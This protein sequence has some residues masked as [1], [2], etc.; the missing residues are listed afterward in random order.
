MARKYTVGML[1]GT[2]GDATLDAALSDMGMHRE[3]R[4]VRH[5]ATWFANHLRL[6]RRLL[7]LF[8]NLSFAQADEMATN[9][10]AAS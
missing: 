7:R 3:N 2:S 10:E 8:P 6:I 4:V 5:S 1:V 9:I